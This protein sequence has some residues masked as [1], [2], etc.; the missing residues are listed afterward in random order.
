M[1]QDAGLSP[2]QMRTVEAALH[3]LAVHLPEVNALLDTSF[4]S[5]SE[6]FVEVANLLQEYG[7]LC[8]KPSLSEAETASKHEIFQRMSALV[9]K[10]IIDMQFQDRVSQN[11]VITVNIAQQIAEALRGRIPEGTPLDTKLTQQLVHLLNLGDIKQKFTAYAQSVGAMSDPAEYGIREAV[12]TAK[13]EEDDIEL[14]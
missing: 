9:G 1:Y 14:F 2:P 12:V 13:A 4:S 6:Q 8:D 11:L 10:T 7:A 3:T 5:I